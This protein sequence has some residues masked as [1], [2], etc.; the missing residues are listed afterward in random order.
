[1]TPFFIRPEASGLSSSVY[2]AGSDADRQLC[3]ILAFAYEAALEA[4]LSPKMALAVIE[5]WLEGERLRTVGA[6][7]TTNEDNSRNV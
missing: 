5:D 2:L 6:R 3:D 4:G 1:M 7:S